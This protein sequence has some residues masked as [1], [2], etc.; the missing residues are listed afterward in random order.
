MSADTPKYQ[1]IAGNY[2]AKRALPAPAPAVTPIV[3]SWLTTGPTPSSPPSEDAKSLMLTQFEMVFPRI[4]EDVC[5]GFTVNQAVDRL[6]PLIRIDLGAFMYWIKKRPKYY[7]LLK[8]SK[9]VRTEIWTGRM[10]DHA[11]GSTKEGM[12]PNEVSRDKLAID[13]YWKLI[14]AENRKEY[15]DKS[16]IEVTGGISIT[17]ALQQAHSRATRVIEAEVV[18]V[19]MLS[20]NQI[21]ELPEEVE[22]EEDSI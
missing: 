3:P 11:T 10:I 13:T 18:D 20:Y 22:V 8:E 19:D 14:S 7:E 6:A 1:T 16:T 9:E 4:L 15:G 5:A 21:L 2:L 12:I 17:T